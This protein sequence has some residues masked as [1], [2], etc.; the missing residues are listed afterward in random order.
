MTQ[1]EFERE[2]QRLLQQIQE[3]N[4]STYELQA[5]IVANQNEVA[6]LQSERTML[7]HAQKTNK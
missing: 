7:R 5:Q 3:Y 4:V 6:R 2:D 1:Q